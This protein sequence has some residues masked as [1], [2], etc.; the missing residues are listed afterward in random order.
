MSA[1]KPG[2][3]YLLKEITAGKWILE[4]VTP[5]ERLSPK[6][7]QMPSHFVIV[8]TSGSYDYLKD[9][10]NCQRFWHLSGTANDDEVRH[11]EDF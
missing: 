4:S 11:I 8:G 9:S 5:K 2:T 6:D 7:V 1:E 10:T 3:A